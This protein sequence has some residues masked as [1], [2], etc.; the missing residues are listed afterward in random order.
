[1]N[2]FLRSTRRH[3]DHVALAPVGEKSWRG[4]GEFPFGI[5]SFNFPSPLGRFLIALLAHFGASLLQLV[6][7][8]SSL[9]VLCLNGGGRI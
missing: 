9:C 4:A 5:Y 1:M 7:L 2:L 3:V 8:D 6:N